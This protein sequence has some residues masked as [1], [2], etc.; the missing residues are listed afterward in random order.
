MTKKEIQQI[1]EGKTAE[2]QEMILCRLGE[3]KLLAMYGEQ[4][5]VETFAE[6]NNARLAK[7]IMQRTGCKNVSVKTVFDNGQAYQIT[8]IDK[9]Q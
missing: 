4:F 3:E 1:A 7:K 5:M 9:K 6:A 8:K 2:V